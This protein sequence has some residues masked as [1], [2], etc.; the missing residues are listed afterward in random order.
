MGGADVGVLEEVVEEC[1]PSCRAV[2]SIRSGS[3]TA[4]TSVAALQRHRVRGERGT[5]D[6]EI[7]VHVYTLPDLSERGHEDR[8]TGEQ[9]S[10]HPSL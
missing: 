3:N 6:L 4:A 2:D 5:G 1:L 9:R 8:V 10:T 7:P